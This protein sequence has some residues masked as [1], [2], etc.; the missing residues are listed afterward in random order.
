MIRDIFDFYS[1]KNE[2]EKNIIDNAKKLKIKGMTDKI[3]NVEALLESYGGMRRITDI[4]EGVAYAY[5]KDVSE[6]LNVLEFNTIDNA[7]TD[8]EGTIHNIAKFVAER[9]NEN[10]MNMGQKVSVFD[11]YMGVDKLKTVEDVENYIKNSTRLN[12]SIE[13]YELVA[14]EFFKWVDK[15]FFYDKASKRYRKKVY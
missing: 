12:K 5:N 6:F 9:L 1:P 10:D 13:M 3:N 11:T 15:N 2:K 14:K 7:G 4:F 8:L